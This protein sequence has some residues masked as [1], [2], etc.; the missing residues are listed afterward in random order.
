ML[1][2]IVSQFAPIL[3]KALSGPFGSVVIDKLADSFGTKPDETAIAKA[4]EADPETAKAQLRYLEQWTISE[5]KRWA[6]QAANAQHIHEVYKAEM[7]RGGFWSWLRP[8][9]GWV[10]IAQSGAFSIVT[11]KHIWNGQFEILAHIPM[12]VMFM[13]PLAAIMGVYFW[14]RSQER[15][16]MLNGSSNAGPNTFDTIQQIVIETVKRIRDGGK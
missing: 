5:A 16:T 9:A 10:T 11:I 7:Q 13:T 2:N 4:I 12:L 3:A 8:A 14:N 1:I 15:R 6:G